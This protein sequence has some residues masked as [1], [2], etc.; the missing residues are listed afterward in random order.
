MSAFQTLRLSIAFMVMLLLKPL[1]G[2][3]AI[4]AEA[5]DSSFISLSSP[6]FLQ[7]SLLRR[8]TLYEYSSAGRHPI[9]PVTEGQRWGLTL[10]LIGPIMTVVGIYGYVNRIDGTKGK[11]WIITGGAGIL[12]FGV[13]FLLL[14][15]FVRNY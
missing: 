11:G 14:R 13:G 4:S 6:R 3:A 5:Q 8:P 7:E 9:D 12:L 10:C 1:E 2:R 15:H